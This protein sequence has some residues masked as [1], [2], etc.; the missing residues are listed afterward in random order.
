MFRRDPEVI[1][2]KFF[3]ERVWFSA[4]RW[5]RLNGNFGFE[6]MRKHEAKRNGRK[7]RKV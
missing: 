5:K 4:K 3:K 7:N 1:I 2:Q 6:K